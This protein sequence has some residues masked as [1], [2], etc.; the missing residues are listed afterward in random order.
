MNR[1]AKITAALSASVV[2]G[3]VAFAV[4]PALAGPVETPA[5]APASPAPTQTPTAGADVPDGYVYIG[6]GMSIPAGGPGDCEAS[7]WIYIDS[8][9]EG[10]AQVEML[11]ADLVDMGPREFAAGEVHVDEQGRPATY[12]V[13]AGDARWAIGDRFCIA[14]GIAL[15]TLNMYPP[16]HAIQPGDVLRLNADLVTDWVNPYGG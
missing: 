14:N 4:A 3:L 12:T 13:A 9:G 16:G 10:S 15:D 7:A 5:A 6:R 2:A 11:G 8:S 1:A